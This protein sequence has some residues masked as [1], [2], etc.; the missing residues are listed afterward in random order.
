MELEYIGDQRLHVKVKGITPE[1]LLGKSSNSI[2]RLPIEI[3][4]SL[5]EFGELFRIRRTTNDDTIYWEGSLERVDH[6]GERM[7]TGRMV[8][9]SSVGSYTGCQMSGGELIVDGNVEEFVAAELRGGQVQINGNANHYAGAMLPGGRVGMQGGSLLIHGSCNTF[10]GYRQRGGLL[11]IKRSALQYCGYQM[12]AGTLV[13]VGNIEEP[14]GIDMIRGTVIVESPPQDNLRFTRHFSLNSTGKTLIIRLVRSQ[15]LE[16]GF[17]CG[18]LGVGDYHSFSGD[19]ANQ[20][21]GELFIATS[22]S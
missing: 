18:D 13:V 4:A 20:S 7:E 14:V 16:L 22:R 17:E 19:T 21:R 11:A 6:L 8:V 10:A 5:I 1:R 15:L 2:K 3:G 9:H 12:L